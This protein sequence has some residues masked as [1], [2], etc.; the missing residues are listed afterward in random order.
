MPISKRWPTILVQFMPVAASLL[1]DEG[2]HAR[3]AAL[4]AMARAHPGCPHG[5]W[6]IMVLVQ[7]LDARVQAALSSAEVAAAQAQGREM[8]VTLTATGLLEELKALAGASQ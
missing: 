2:Q 7:G 3:A 5:W 6:E 4:M 1:A 8:D